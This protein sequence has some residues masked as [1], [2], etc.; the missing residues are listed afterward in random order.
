MADRGRLLPLVTGSSRPKAVLQEL[1]VYQSLR[2]LSQRDFTHWG[3]ALEFL[4]SEKLPALPAVEHQR[5][6]A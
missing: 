5:R 4:K 6:P 1:S 3:G 2:V